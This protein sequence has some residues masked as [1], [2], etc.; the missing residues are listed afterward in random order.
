MDATFSEIQEI[1]KQATK[2]LFSSTTYIVKSLAKLLHSLVYMVFCAM[3]QLKDLS[4]HSAEADKKIER[5][6][7]QL[8]K[9]VSEDWITTY[10]SP[11]FG[12]PDW[13]NKAFQKV[14]GDIEVGPCTLRSCEL[15]HN[16]IDR[17]L[18]NLQGLTALILRFSIDGV[19]MFYTIY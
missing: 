1:F 8:H 5:M 7:I 16:I 18:I 3:V 12:D 13:T 14:E 9:S 19:L 4:L 2:K 11:T 10:F 17:L 6:W 15:L